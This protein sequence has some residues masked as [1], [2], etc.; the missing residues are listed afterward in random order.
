MQLYS[1]ILANLL[2]MSNITSKFTSETDQ[3]RSEGGGA[4]GGPH[5][6]PVALLEGCILEPGFRFHDLQGSPWVHG[7]TTRALGWPQGPMGTPAVWGIHSR[8]G[9]QLLFLLFPGASSQMAP[10]ILGDR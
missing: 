4:M 8:E 5:P 6:L 7:L 2:V 3:I 10:Q 1:R 9:S